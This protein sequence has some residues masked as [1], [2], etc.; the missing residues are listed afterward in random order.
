MGIGLITFKTARPASKESRDKNSVLVFCTIFDQM[1][2]FLDRF[3]DLL[4]MHTEMQ[5]HSH[6]NCPV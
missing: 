4:N 1:L 6:I 2:F 3:N 5:V